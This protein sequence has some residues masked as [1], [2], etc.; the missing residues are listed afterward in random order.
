[1]TETYDMFTKPREKSPNASAAAKFHL[2]HHMICMV[3]DT[4]G[5]KIKYASN[6][7]FAISK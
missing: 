2:F 1:M 7:L 3:R 4:F 6:Y 5:Y